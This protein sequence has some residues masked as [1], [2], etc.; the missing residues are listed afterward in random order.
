MRPLVNS[1]FYL[2]LLD[3]KKKRVIKRAKPYLK[4]EL[5]LLNLLCD[6]RLF[7]IHHE[8][9]NYDTAFLNAYEKRCLSSR[10]KFEKRQATMV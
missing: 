8:K 2:C 6:F 1:V 9:P 5:N 10:M 4:I 7:R 3:F